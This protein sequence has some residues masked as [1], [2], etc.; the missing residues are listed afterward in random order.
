MENPT[1]LKLMIQYVYLLDYPP[2]SGDNR[3]GYVV[4]GYKGRMDFR[5]QRSRSSLI[6]VGSN[7]DAVS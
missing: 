6:E 3:S 7:P 5:Y 1:L 4:D 2:V